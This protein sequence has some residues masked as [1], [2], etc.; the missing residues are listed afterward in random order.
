MY[1]LLPKD[2][3]RPFGILL[4]DIVDTLTTAI[5]LDAE[6]YRADGLLG[7]AVVRAQMTLF[8]DV[9]RLADLLEQ[10]S[11][12]RLPPPPERRG[13]RALLV[14]DTQFF[15]QLVKGY[16][17]GAGFEVE[18]ARD[19]AEGLA[20]LD[21]GTFDLIVSDIEMPVMDG[22]AFARAVRQRPDGAR[23]PLLA[24]TTL[25]SAVDRERALACGFDR[26]EVKIDRERFLAA[27]KELLG[28]LSPLSPV[29]GGEGRNAAAPS[30]PAP[31]P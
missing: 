31:L 16:L 6:A 9:Y 22:W 8:L 21:E 7:S 1:L 12:A 24:L 2:L 19:G 30:P 3:R 28:D 14:E 29:L 26:H 18:L 27:V 20:K 15:R 4:S 13:R 25:S 23:V 17:E 11:R 5:E 10:A